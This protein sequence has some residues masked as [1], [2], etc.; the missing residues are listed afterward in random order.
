MNNHRGKSG[1]KKQ[2]VDSG[3][4]GSACSDLDM[5]QRAGATGCYSSRL[6][7]CQWNTGLAEAFSGK[8]RVP[9]TK[10][11]IIHSKMFY[12]KASCSSRAECVTG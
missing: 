10:R 5:G 8:Q 4:A 2:E 1:M 9:K 12:L 11:K 6:Q 3:Q 7:S